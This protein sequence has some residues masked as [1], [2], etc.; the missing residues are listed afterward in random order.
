MILYEFEC[1]KCK[2]V[3]EEFAPF[4][5]T[6][7]YPGVVC[8]ECKST[9]KIR[10]FGATAFAFANPVGTDRWNSQSQ[11]HDYRFKHNIPNVK[12]QRENAMNKSHM[13]SDPYPV[14]DDVNSGKYFGD[15]K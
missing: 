12:A 7:K 10:V 4:D 5:E 11:G 15:V 3:Y 9:R 1:K 14:V 2:T 8:P 6:S 13:G